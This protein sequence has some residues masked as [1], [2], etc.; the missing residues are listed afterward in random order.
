MKRFLAIILSLVLVCSAIVAQAAVTDGTYEAEA[1]GMF[2]GLKVAVTFAEGKIAGVEV[3]SHN[4]TAGISDPAIERI[5]AA[6]VENNSVLVDA[7]SGSTMT[8]KGIVAAV[9]AAIEA[10]GGN[11]ADF[12]TE[13][14]AEEVARTEKTIEVDVVVAGAGLAGLTAAVTAA[15]AGASVVLLEKTARAGGSLS[16]AGGN[17]VSVN[18]AIG[19][20]YGI[21][22][23]KEA[24]MAYWQ[25]CVDQSYDPN[26]GYPNMERL[27][28]LLD[29][30]DGILTWMKD[31]GVPFYKGSDVGAQTVAKIYTDGKGAAVTA[32]L[33]K[34]ALEAGVTILY[35]TPAVEIVMEDGKAVGL[36]AQSATE[37]IT[38]K[39]S[40]GVMLATGGFGANF[41]LLGEWV[42]G[43]ANAK[44]VV[45]PSHTADGHL[46]A[47]AIGAKLYDNMW[48]MPS[49]L[50][51]DAD[52]SANVADTSFFSYSALANRALVNEEGKRFT[53]EYIGN[54]YAVLTNAVAAEECDV[55][56]ILDASDEAMT[57]SLEE[58]AAKGVIA[59]ADTIEALA[60]A[61][62]LPELPA[63]FAAYNEYCAAGADAEFAKDPGYLT[64]YAAEGPY[65]AVK[66]G[67]ALLGSMG[68]VVTDIDG[69]VYDVNDAVIPGLYA[70]GEMSNREFYNQVYVGAAS[71][72][73]YPISAQLA[74][75]DMLK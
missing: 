52:V 43:Y 49:G 61:L 64:A 9:K 27:E 26:T 23:N 22:D 25:W 55:Y 57:V 58:G 16:L 41:E 75:A 18:S 36:K 47:Q 54:A 48:V 34:A 53:N 35:E 13:I 60:E 74:V 32:A 12:E 40:K 51:L 10:A 2:D 19:K 42:P 63:T 28:T 7:V 14:A 65:Y 72:S 45:A 31:H 11:V 20:E 39:A 15:D 67:P 3:V 62:N 17:F 1:K 33:E 70:A 6:I 37:D 59:K 68:G 38:V 8:S 29:N 5:P 30:V 44:S 24:T 69:R 21:D 50:S 56:Y 66:F 46:M 4:E 71:L 73:L